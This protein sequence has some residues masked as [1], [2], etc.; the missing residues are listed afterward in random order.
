M[1]NCQHYKFYRATP[2]R[3]PFLTQTKKFQKGWEYILKIQLVSDSSSNLKQMANANFSSAPLKVI[4]G[5]QE[6]TDDETI[7]LPAMMKALK[8]YK[9]KTS[10]ACP[11]VEDWTKAFGDADVVLGATITSGLSG[12]YNCARIAAEEYTDAHPDRKVFIFDSL[13]TGTELELLMEKIQELSTSSL[14]F[15]EQCSALVEYSKHTHLMFSLESLENFA[16]NG[17]VSPA[18]AKAVGILGIRIVGKASAEG[19]LEPMHKCRGE[20]TPSSVCSTVCWRRVTAAERFA[21]PTP[22]I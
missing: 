22:T 18:V 20:K 21:S 2:D 9:G 15:E 8:Q 14:S 5:D 1:L 3:N 16:K 12:C 19:T 13:S 17:R 11:S 10:T 6:F 7:D 4:V